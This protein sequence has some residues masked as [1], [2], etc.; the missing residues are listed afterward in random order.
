MKVMVYF[1]YGLLGEISKG[2]K[3]VPKLIQASK[4]NPHL[5]R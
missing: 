1:E 3:T 5:N 4:A 2:T